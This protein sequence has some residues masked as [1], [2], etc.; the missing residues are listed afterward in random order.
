MR[1]DKKS[2][3]IKTAVHQSISGILYP[4]S[5]EALI[6][7]ARAKGDGNDVV[8]LLEK[9][10]PLEYLNEPHVL[11]TLNEYVNA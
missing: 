6:E 3:V 11:T 8:D 9:L 1:E 5:K 7:Y 10:P 4:T 2:S